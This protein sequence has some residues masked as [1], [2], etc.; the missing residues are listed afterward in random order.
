MSSNEER[1]SLEHIQEKIAERMRMRDLAEP[2]IR[3]MQRRVRL[4]YE[5]ASGK[6]DWNKIGG[7]R[8]EDYAHIDKLEAPGGDRLRE[9]LGKLAVI[10]LNGGLGTSMGLTKAKS[11]IRVKDEY[12]FLEIIRRQIEA[13]RAKHGVKLPL[14]FMNSF[15][16]QDDTLAEPG[17]REI[18]QDVPGDIPPDFVQ[19]MIPR[20]DQKTLL[21]VGDGNDPNDWTPPGHGDVFLSLQITGILEKLLGQG[22][23][24]AFLSNGDNLGASVHEGLLA[25]MHAEGLEW[26]SEVTPKTN[27]DLKGGVLYRRKTAEGT[28]PIEL[29]ETAQVPEEHLD[30]FK[31]VSRFAHFNINNLWVN[32]EALR[33]RLRSESL[34]LSLIVNPK[35]VEGR[36]VYQ[37]ETAMGAAIGQF[38]KSRVVITPRRRFAPVKD[39]GDLLVRRSDCYVLNEDTWILER[40]P[41]RSLDA[42]P[43]VKLD[44]AYKK[45]AD[46]ERLVPEIPSLVEAEE[47]VVEG[48]VVFDSPLKI[49]GRV[50]L[51]SSGERGVS[52]LGRAELRDE[53]V[54]L[55]GV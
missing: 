31:D 22:Y 9:D 29:L 8:E 43:V 14:L 3:E 30:D 34:N 39:N 37:L 26:I 17:I 33:D 23:Q 1:P 15:N 42:E 12:S 2:V 51:A 54:D 4:V 53:S 55:S 47:L 25:F 49:A 28:G 38:A 52:V 21:P 50:K 32:L 48:P 7:L 5:G 45:I 13:L 46:F 36:N 19:N 20:L 40:N 41:Q 10:K 27:V 24:T 11:L 6:V 35:N 44:P 16:T 18:N